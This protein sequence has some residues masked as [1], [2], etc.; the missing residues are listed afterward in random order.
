MLIT[1][2]ENTLEFFHRFAKIEIAN[3][4]WEVQAVNKDSGDGVI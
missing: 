1:K 4:M 3:E 2:D